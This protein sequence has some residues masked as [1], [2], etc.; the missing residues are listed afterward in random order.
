MASA[1]LQRSLA[2]RSTD[3]VLVAVA[4]L[5]HAYHRH[6]ENKNELATKH[7]PRCREFRFKITML[8]FISSN[9]LIFDP[10]S[11]ATEVPSDT[12]SN[13]LEFRSFELRKG[14]ALALLN[15]GAE[16][17]THPTNS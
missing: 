13:L 10:V 1:M 5:L 12:L 2:R 7:R 9:L 11:A 14:R 16:H 4:S 8:S 15:A 17:R 6:R 3:L